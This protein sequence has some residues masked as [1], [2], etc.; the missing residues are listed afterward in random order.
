[1]K[2]PNLEH[3]ENHTSIF[4]KNV[5]MQIQIE[6]STLRKKGKKKEDNT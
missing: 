2:I 3:L 4:N 5:N 6:N 1:M